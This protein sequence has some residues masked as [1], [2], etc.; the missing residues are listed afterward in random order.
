MPESRAERRPGLD[1][2]GTALLT[3]ALVALILPLV[4][5]RQ[6]GWPLWSW[7][8]LAAVPLCLAGLVIQQR[9]RARRRQGTLLSRELLRERAFSGGL[10]FQLLFW[11]GEASFFLVLAVPELEASR[12]E[13]SSHAGVGQSQP[14]GERRSGD[15][16]AALPTGG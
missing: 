9:R 2:A 7:S 13:L 5:G 6:Q 11:S 15:R 3:G 8:C 10:S 14:G 4:E 1:P 16:R 12:V